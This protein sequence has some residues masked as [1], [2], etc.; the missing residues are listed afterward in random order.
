MLIIMELTVLLEPLTIKI[1]TRKGIITLLGLPGMA[2][3]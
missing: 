1:I 2:S 3:G